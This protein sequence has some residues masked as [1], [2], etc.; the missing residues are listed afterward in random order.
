V[1]ISSACCWDQSAIWLVKPAD[2]HSEWRQTVLHPRRHGRVHGPGDQPIPFQGA[3]RLRQHLL[4]DALREPTQLAEAHRPLVPTG[5]PVRAWSGGTASRRS[6]LAW[7]SRAL[8][9]T[10]RI[11]SGQVTPSSAVCSRRSRPPRRPDR[12]AARRSCAG[13][14]PRREAPVPRELGVDEPI[15]YTS[16]DFVTAARDIDVRFGF[17]PSGPDLARIAASGFV[18]FWARKPSPRPG[19]FHPVVGFFT[20]RANLRPCDHL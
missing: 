19:E 9:R 12:Q 16:T 15:D 14:R 8:S 20:R 3:E 4:R 2:I 18:S 5:I 7:T 13:H 17:T 10:Q 6:P 11:P 1:R